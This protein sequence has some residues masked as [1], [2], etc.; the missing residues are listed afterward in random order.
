MHSIGPRGLSTEVRDKKLGDPIS[1]SVSGRPSLESHA[2]SRKCVAL[3]IL[4]LFCVVLL[5]SIHLLF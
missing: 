3:H 4:S 2:A 5:Y 1:R